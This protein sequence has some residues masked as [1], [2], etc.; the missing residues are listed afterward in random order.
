MSVA[1]TSLEV[2][3]PISLKRMARLYASSPWPQP[4]LH[5]SGERIGQRRC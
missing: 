3:L 5:S 4:A 2:E 1:T